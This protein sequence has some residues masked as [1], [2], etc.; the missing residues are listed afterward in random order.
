MNSQKVRD[1]L[2]IIGIFAVVA[3]LVFVGL[4]MRQDHK[5]QLSQAYQSRT[6][7][8]A[9]WNTALAANPVALSGY[10]KAVEGR[11]DEISS[12]E[13]QAL[14]RMIIGVLYLYDNAHYQY[15][16]GF[17][18]EEFW[19]SSRDNMRGWLQ[20]ETTRKIFVERIN[21][22]GR[23]EFKEVIRALDAKVDADDG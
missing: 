7:A 19:N 20:N 8:A 17:I 13:Y 18:S 16:Q 5:I 1:W 2:E 11:E 14:H 10:H 12:S 3:S 4:Q 22:Q 21:V 23:P 9:E 15:Q 6:A